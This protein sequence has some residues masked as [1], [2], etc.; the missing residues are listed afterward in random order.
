MKR[1][2]KSKL[3]LGREVVKTLVT[4]LQ[5]AH[6]QHVRGGDEPPYNSLVSRCSNKCSGTLLNLQ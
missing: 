2:T 3:V 5:D 1:A 6:L 4:V